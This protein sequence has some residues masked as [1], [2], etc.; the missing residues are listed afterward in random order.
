MTIERQAARE[1]ALKEH[2]MSMPAELLRAYLCEHVDGA[3]A[4]TVETLIVAL[5]GQ[6]KMPAIAS[7]TGA[8]SP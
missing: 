8:A 7:N 3:A 2:I 4:I 1:A 5:H 6:S